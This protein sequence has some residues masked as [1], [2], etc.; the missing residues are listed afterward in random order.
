MTADEI[1]QF[2][3][4]IGDKIKSESDVITV[5]VEDIVFNLRFSNIIDLTVYKNS[6]LVNSTDY[7]LDVASGSVIFID[8][9][10]VDTEVR[11]DYTYAAYT[12]DEIASLVEAYGFD[13]AVLEV[14]YELLADAARMYDYSE[15]A[16]QAKLSQVF[17]HVQKLIDMYE[18]KS[19]GFQSDSGTSM[20][21]VSIGKRITESYRRGPKDD[22]DLSR[23]MNR[24]S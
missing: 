12:D 24:L 17:D 3:R 5:K 20:G 21:G 10:A 9:V 2:R 19:E 6:D 11:F 23:Y 16:T 8:M 14:L 22:K 13:K 18:K 7:T 4:R 15:G 1:N